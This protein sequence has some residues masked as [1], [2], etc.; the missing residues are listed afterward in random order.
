MFSNENIQS[1]HY[2]DDFG[3]DFTSF[4]NSDKI[5]QITYNTKYLPSY[6][7]FYIKLVLEI[8][9]YMSLAVDCLLDLNFVGNIY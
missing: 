3:V 5:K 8:S 9:N 1:Y 6:P 2:V 4:N 7:Y